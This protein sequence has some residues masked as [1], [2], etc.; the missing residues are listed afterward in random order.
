MH[1]AVAGYSRFFSLWI[2]LD[3]RKR[4]SL[5]WLPLSMD[6]YK[7]QSDL[8]ELTAVWG[9]ICTP[10]PLLDLDVWSLTN[11]TC[12]GMFILVCMRALIF[13]FDFRR[14]HQKWVQH[15]FKN[16]MHA[17]YLTQMRKA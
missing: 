1:K 9:N 2:S 8:K 4:K 6:V 5:D 17:P 12:K 14:T 10:P 15:P 13:Y 7:L 3:S 16:G 11:S